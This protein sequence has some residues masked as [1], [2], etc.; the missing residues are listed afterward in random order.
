MRLSRTARFLIAALLIAAAAFVW[1]NLFNQ[2]R[3]AEP[4]QAAGEPAPIS[5][6]NGAAAPPGAAAPG[7]A[8]G[9]APAGP[10]G[11]E[12]SAG[13]QAGQAG[14]EGAQAA[15]GEGQEGAAPL[16]PPVV[17][18]EGA[19]VV[20][21]ELVIDELPFLVLGPPEGGAEQAAAEGEG[22]SRPQATQRATINPFS[23]VVVQAPAAPRQEVA[24]QPPASTPVVEVVAE[25]PPPRQPVTQAAPRAPA[26]P[27][28]APAPRT[29]A[30]AGP[31]AADLP[32]ALPGGVL[33]S[34]PQ[35][36][37]DARS[38]P[39]VVEPEAPDVGELAAL[40]EP[41]DEGGPEPLGPGGAQPAEAEAPAPDLGELAAIREPGEDAAVQVAPVDVA[42]QAAAAAVPDPLGPGRSE[43][44][45][46]DANPSNALPLVVGADPLSRYLR[47]NDV[48]FTGTVLGPL[49]VGVFRSSVYAAPVVLTLGQALP[50]T[51]IILS[52]LRGYEARFTQ[53]DRTQTLS[54]DLR[55]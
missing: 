2:T 25:A 28:R 50:D 45:R 32:R 36:L 51:D 43:E 27:V 33:P 17:V 38:Q 3:T 46:A 4:T 29:V 10:A 44:A 26:E 7:A 42:P 40:R 54:L 5:V 12:A 47:D 16:A 13:G 8:A 21:R 11:A 30:P 6:P 49:S 35:I 22:A 53:G 14:A 9:Q 23:P 39:T 52:D 41:T 19:Q 24:A 18:A 1:V 48:R 15:A 34:T 37:R 20:T 55:R 31:V